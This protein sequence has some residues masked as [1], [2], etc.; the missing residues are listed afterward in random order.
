MSKIIGFLCYYTI[1]KLN[2]EADKLKDILNKSG[3]DQT[4]IVKKHSDT[5]AFKRASSS[6]RGNFKGYKLKMLDNKKEG[7]IISREIMKETPDNKNNI[8]TS[9][10]NVVYNKAERSM[11]YNINKGLGLNDDLQEITNRVEKSIEIFQ[12]EKSGLNEDR[13]SNIV[14]KYMKNILDASRVE[15]HGKLWFVPA[16]KI[17]QLE[18]I[19]DLFKRLDRSVISSSYTEIMSLPIPEEE[20]YI[21]RYSREFITDISI[22]LQNV[23]NKLNECYKN[24]SLKNTIVTWKNK[25]TQLI[26]KIEMHDAIFECSIKMKMESD[27]FKLIKLINI[28]QEDIER[29]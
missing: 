3:I 29:K 19:E 4:I 27:I 8:I 25:G 17:D 12:Q 16:Y 24:N 6:I 9:I 14:D 28:E 15:I 18:K 22:E 1:G 5:Q 26:K 7:N 13:I 23:I 20:K 11:S 10:G 21:E 2:I